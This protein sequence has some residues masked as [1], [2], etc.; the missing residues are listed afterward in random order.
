M[1]NLIYFTLTTAFILISGTSFGST[2]RPEPTDST[3][4]V[5]DKTAAIY[6]IE[7][8]KTLYGDGKIK[9]ALIK[10]REAGVKDPY[11]WHASYW[12]AQCH[13]KMNNYGYA[14]KY[15]NKAIELGG[16]K[17]SEEIFFT[18]GCTYHRL[19]NIDS[20]LINYTLANDKLPKLRSKT[21]MIEHL[22]EECNFAKEELS[23]A[24]LYKRKRLIGDINSGFDDY[25][26][27]LV[28][29]GK[30]IYFISRRSN[31]TG[32]GMNPDDQTFFEDIYKVS[33]EEELKEWDDA[34]NNLGKINSNGFDALNYISPDGLYGVMTLNSTATDL[35]KTS[36]GS[37]LCEIKLNDKGTWNTPKPIAN[38]TINTSFFEGAA[39]LTA[40]GNTM[41]FVTDRKGEKSSTDIYVATKVGKAW[42]DA[43]P[44]PMT[45]NTPGRETTPFIT[46]DGRYLFFSSDGHLGLGGLDVYV[47]ENLGDSWGTPIN[48]GNGINS[49]NN[50]THFTYYPELNKGF[51]SAFEIVGDKSSL[52]IY[53]LDLTNFTIPKGK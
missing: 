20:A 46:P 12:I 47:V 34:T 40:D 42:G 44:L 28:D 16:E 31:T 32:G 48:L 51:V 45:V 27:L 30:T 50:D 36:R 26:A 13:Y 14:L 17:V 38:K 9:D 25:G 8:G 19:E 39:T 22:I 35:K 43:K 49:V 23:K 6:M 11:S 37:D 5:V 33:W 4:S 53:E 18:L 15:A 41:Y 24:P 52:D 10:F 29:G 7:E 1:N 3:T 2:L 21:L